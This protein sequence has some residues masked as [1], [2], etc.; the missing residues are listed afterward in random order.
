MIAL[1]R[2][3]RLAAFARSFLCC[4][5]ETVCAVR[6]R[7]RIGGLQCRRAEPAG[8][9]RPIDLGRVL[10]PAVAGAESRT[11]GLPGC[12]P[13]ELQCELLILN[14]SPRRSGSGPLKVYGWGARDIEAAYNL[15]SMSKGSEE[16][17]A[18]IDSYDNPNVASDLAAY[19]RYY[20]L[21]KG[22]FYKFNQDGQQSHYPKR[23]DSGWILEIDLDVEM[24]AAA[25]PNCTIYLVESNNSSGSSGD[26]A[27]GGSRE[28]GRTHH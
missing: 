12:R 6:C 20:G 9:D 27:E 26:K 7:A 2:G 25:C 17:V 21:P 24:V 4:E 18:V 8:G 5:A 23:G 14:E 19:R 3:S 1:R 13:G 15:P 11:P 28:A 22:R 16:I 10:D